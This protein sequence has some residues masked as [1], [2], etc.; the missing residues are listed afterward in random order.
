[1]CVYTAYN[2]KMGGAENKM[3]FHTDVKKRII[4]L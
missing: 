2:F 4:S 1:M 3:K